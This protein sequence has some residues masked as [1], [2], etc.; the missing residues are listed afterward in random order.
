VANPQLY[1]EVVLLVAAGLL[2]KQFGTLFDTRSRSTSIKT[3]VSELPRLSEKDTYRGFIETLAGLLAGRDFPRAVIVHNYD[4]LD[5]LT[6][7]VLQ[8]YLLT[9]AKRAIGSEVWVVFEKTEGDRL[10]QFL[11]ATNDEWLLDRFHAFKQQLLSAEARRALARELRRPESA[12]EFSTVKSV[13]REGGQTEKDISQFFQ[14]YR[15]QHPEQ[16]GRYDP[17]HL[18]YIISLAATPGSV[19]FGVD[20][21]KTT[22]ADQGVLRSQILRQLLPGTRL[23]PREFHEAFPALTEFP[24]NVLQIDDGQGP[25]AVRVTVETKTVLCQHADLFHLPRVGLVHLYWSFLLYDR[26]QNHPLETFWIRKLLHHIAMATVSDLT[27]ENLYATVARQL[28]DLHMYAVGAA[29]KTCLLRDVPDLLIG[30][31]S[32]MESPDSPV[33]TSQERRLLRLCWEAYAVLGDDRILRTVLGARGSR[34]GGGLS[35]G[36]ERE[37]ALLM[38]FT[39][40]QTLSPVQRELMT[41]EFFRWADSQFPGNES[42]SDDCRLRAAWLILTVAPLMD[43]L[44]ASRLLRCLQQ[45]TRIVPDLVGRVSIRG[46]GEADGGLRL[47]DI[48]ALSL[49]VWCN[50]LTFH[51]RITIALL[52]SRVAEGAAPSPAPALTPDPDGGAPG[53][54]TVRHLLPDISGLIEAAETSVLLASYLGG[55]QGQTTRLDRD[56]GVLANGL[57]RELCAISV[58]SIQFACHALRARDFGQPSA[59]DVSRVG[60][61]LKICESVLGYPLPAVTSAQD[62]LSPELVQKVGTLLSACEILWEDVGVSRLRDMIALRRVH[63]NAVC[64]DLG[65][66][67]FDESTSLMQS[68]SAT[69]TDLPPTGLLA[70]LMVAVCLLETEELAAHYLCHATRLAVSHNCSYW[71]RHELSMVAMSRAHK[72]DYDLTDLVDS[73]LEEHAEGSPFLAGFLAQLPPDEVFRYALVLLNA[74]KSNRASPRGDR[75]LEML[76]QIAQD[77]TSA[78]AQAELRSLLDFLQLERRLSSGQTIDAGAALEAWRGKHH[79]PVY[80]SLLAMLLQNGCRTPEVYREVSRCLVAIPARTNTQAICISRW[81]WAGDERGP[82]FSRRGQGTAVVSREGRHSVGGTHHR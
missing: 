64:R 78:S 16:E 46:K 44:A 20:D 15:L 81:R 58:A 8:E 60:Q 65:A 68:I 17:L 7:D 31:L 23:A 10:S 42:I 76:E 79:V 37:D 14:D 67:N 13:C 38:L 71:L 53:D 70:N 57:A 35:D 43:L 56:R 63:F 62:L 21:L 29:M 27:D 61:I 33:R 45:A 74:A 39:G 69:L 25:K 73:V 59:S 41:A 82:A 66:A 18:L 30:A 3:F 5:L 47:S 11:R 55:R 28:F 72:F 36:A 80:S 52:M 26:L 48:L 34:G 12:A 75:V 50:A 77:L 19:S 54:A 22:F 49:A 24:A 32:L 6:K 9:F 40:T 4:E 2:I 1:G 51:P